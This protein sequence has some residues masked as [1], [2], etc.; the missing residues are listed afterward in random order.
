MKPLA[1]VM[2]TALLIAACGSD[3]VD[4]SATGT[5]VTGMVTA[6]SD[7]PPISEL[8]A[9]AVLRVS[10]QNVSLADA[11]AVV[12]STVDF[13]LAGEEF[14]IAYELSYSL[15]DVVD[16]NTYS[17]SARVEAG[18]DLLMI[19]DTMTP[20][21]TRGAPTSDITVALVYIAAN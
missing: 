1:L 3:D 19:S 10:L 14:P 16:T 12:I 18:G 8:P 17:V 4:D 15:G 11:P 2:A 20:V 5:S 13:D 6:P 7:A 9:N 21:I